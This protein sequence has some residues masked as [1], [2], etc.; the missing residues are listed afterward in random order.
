[1]AVHEITEH[2]DGSADEYHS[3]S[4]DEWH[5][6]SEWLKRG[7]THAHPDMTASVQHWKTDTARQERTTNALADVFAVA[8]Y[9]RRFKLV[10][11]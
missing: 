9:D 8:Q 4:A 5:T 11:V 6:F 10:T 3:F 7:G 1:M 2:P